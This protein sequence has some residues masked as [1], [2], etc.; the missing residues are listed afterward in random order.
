MSEIQ[1]VIAD[2]DG[3]LLTPEKELTERA[4]RAV[5]ALRSARVA[6]ALTSGRPPRGIEMLFA[7]LGITTPV[8]AFNG[9]MLVRSDLS[10][11]EQQILPTAIVGQVIDALERHG[12]D[13]WLY[14]GVDWFVRTATAP[15]VDRERRTVEFAPTVLPN[16]DE[17]HEGIVKI[18]GISDD[19]AAVARCE[20]D[21]RQQFGEHV[22]AARS[23]PYYLDVTHPQANKGAVV[24]RLSELL[25]VP[26]EQVATL[27]DMP[28]DVSMFAQSGVSIAMGNASAEVQRAAHRVT[29]SNAEE[30]FA[31]A[32]EKFVLA[33]QV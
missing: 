22:S 7:P 11:I 30:G 16:F 1:L 24:R 21:V 9:G 4:R 31:D 2:V 23:Q 27:G 19:L 8:A 18:V 3:T 14:H 33:R 15:H 6:F 29:G 32:I 25:K 5:A 10:L 13:V 28:N 12:L 17:M 26:T 20:G